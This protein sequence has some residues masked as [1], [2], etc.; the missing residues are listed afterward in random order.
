MRRARSWELSGFHVCEAVTVQPLMGQVMVAPE[1][2]L[3]QARPDVRQASAVTG[4]GMLPPFEEVAGQNHS[5]EGRL[6]P[7]ILISERTCRLE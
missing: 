2:S 3:G 5:L 6:Q 7:Y 4:N 1:H